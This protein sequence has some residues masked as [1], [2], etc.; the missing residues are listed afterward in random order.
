MKNNL[1]FSLYLSDNIV[2][3]DL[4]FIQKITWMILLLYFCVLYEESLSLHSLKLQWSTKQRKWY[5][6]G[7]TWGVNNDRIFFFGWTNP[8]KCKLVTTKHRI[9][10]NQIETGSLLPQ[11]PWYKVKRW[12]LMTPLLLVEPSGE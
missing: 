6:F 10:P 5:R 7:M 3:E 11:V 8:L 2:P 9:H 4:E 12:T 1:N